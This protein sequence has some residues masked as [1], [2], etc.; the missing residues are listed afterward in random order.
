MGMVTG[1]VWVFGYICICDLQF[2]CIHVGSYAAG[3]LDT[4]RDKFKSEAIG[5]VNMSD[6]E[7]VSVY[8]PEAQKWEKKFL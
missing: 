1:M 4:F 8:Q 2:K 7:R 6:G 3:W 5:E